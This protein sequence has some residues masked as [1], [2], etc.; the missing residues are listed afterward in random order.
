MIK[1][2]NNGKINSLEYMILVIFSSRSLYNGI[3][4]QNMLNFSKIDIHD[5][6]TISKVENEDEEVKHASY[7]CSRCLRRSK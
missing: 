7:S 2:F 1:E 5:I 6:A 4:I 3:G